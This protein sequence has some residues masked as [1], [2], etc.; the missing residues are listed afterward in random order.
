MTKFKDKGMGYQST[1]DLIPNY[2][3]AK[4]SYIHIVIFK[5]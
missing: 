5:I 1:Q 3:Y 4:I 2:Q